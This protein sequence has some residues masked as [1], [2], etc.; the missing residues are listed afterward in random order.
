MVVMLEGLHERL[1]QNV[2]FLPLADREQMAGCWLEG[3]KL[4]APDDSVWRAR[5]FGSTAEWEFDGRRHPAGSGFWQS[6]LE[7]A[8]W[9]Q[10]WERYGTTLTI[11]ARSLRFRVL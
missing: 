2:E 4:Y 8:W 6:H 9:E 3:L 11:M 10:L 1:T 7:W 5:Q